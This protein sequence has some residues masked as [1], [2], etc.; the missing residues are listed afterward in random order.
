MNTGDDDYDEFF[1]SLSGD[2]AAMPS[3]PAPQEPAVAGGAGGSE[4]G[5]E[6]VTPTMPTKVPR[7]PREKLVIDAEKLTLDD[8]AKFSSATAIKLSGDSTRAFGEFRSNVSSTYTPREMQEFVYDLATLV[9]SASPAAAAV[10]QRILS[11]GDA[12]HADVASANYYAEVKKR[13]FSDEAELSSRGIKSLEVGG[14]FVTK[15]DDALFYYS[16]ETTKL[17]TVRFGAAGRVTKTVKDLQLYMNPDGSGAKFAFLPPAAKNNAVP[18]SML[19]MMKKARAPSYFIAF[20]VYAPD[21]LQRLCVFE[22]IGGKYVSVGVFGTYE[23]RLKMINPSVGDTSM[24]SKTDTVPDVGHSKAFN[25]CFVHYDDASGRIDADMPGVYPK[26]KIAVPENRAF[27]ARDIVAQYIQES[28]PFKHVAIQY[29]S[30]LESPAQIGIDDLADAVKEIPGAKIVAITEFGSITVA[31][32]WRSGEDLLLVFVERR[33]TYGQNLAPA[34]VYTAR[35]V[36]S[37]NQTTRL[38][39]TVRH[40]IIATLNHVHYYDI[41]EL[42]AQSRVAPSPKAVAPPVS[43]EPAPEPAPVPASPPAAIAQA[44]QPPAARISDAT[45]VALVMTQL[46]TLH[47]GK[48]MFRNMTRRYMAETIVYLARLLRT[49]KSLMNEDD[50]DYRDYLDYYDKPLWQMAT[51]GL[52]F[53]DKHPLYKENKIPPIRLISTQDQVAVRLDSDK[54]GGIVAMSLTDSTKMYHLYVDQMSRKKSAFVQVEYGGAPFVVQETVPQAEREFVLNELLTAR[55]EARAQ[56]LRDPAPF[57]FIQNDEVRSD[58]FVAYEHSPGNEAF[59]IVGQRRGTDAD[60]DDARMPFAALA[61]FSRSAPPAVKLG[62]DIKLAFGS[63]DTDERVVVYYDGNVVQARTIA[64]GLNRT[65]RDPKPDKTSQNA[66]FAVSSANSTLVVA[67]REHPFVVEL[68]SLGGGKRRYIS[69][70]GRDEAD[71]LLAV[72]YL[73]RLVFAVFLTSGGRY[74]LGIAFV[75]DL[76]DETAF[77]TKS[78]AKDAQFGPRY[79]SLPASTTTPDRKNPQ[80]ALL[81]VNPRRLLVSYDDGP[82]YEY[83]FLL[84]HVEK[85]PP[86]LEPV[87][88]PVAPPPIAPPPAEPSVEAAP[89]PA[90]AAPAASSP[91][92][93]PAPAPKPLQLVPPVASTER[94]TNEAAGDAPSLRFRVEADGSMSVTYSP[95]FGSEVLMTRECDAILV[96]NVGNYAEFVDDL[97]FNM[98]RWE[99]EETLNDLCVLLANRRLEYV[100]EIEDEETTDAEGDESGDEDDDD[101][102][103]DEGEELAAEFVEESDFLYTLDEFNDM[104]PNVQEAAKELRSFMNDLSFQEITA[105]GA[106]PDTRAML[107]EARE[108]YFVGNTTTADY[109]N[110]IR[111][112]F[113]DNAGVEA[114][115]RD[116]TRTKDAYVAWLAYRESKDATEERARRKV[117]DA[118]ALRIRALGTSE[119]RQEYEQRLNSVFKSLRTEINRVLIES[120]QAAGET[121]ASSRVLFMPMKDALRVAQKNEDDVRL[122]R[123]RLLESLRR[124]RLDYFQADLLNVR[125]K[126]RALVR[127]INDA[128]VSMELSEATQYEEIASAFLTVI[129]SELGTKAK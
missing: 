87:A 60:D 58:I 11:N 20:R 121:V 119:Q 89:E 29:K 106:E 55:A 74:T 48:K 50:F 85:V 76:L 104:S 32:V 18:E 93:R 98:R 47:P 66:S 94:R 35:G 49:M 114:Y 67:K 24:R 110:R 75:P 8:V 46:R 115:L 22:K 111:T 113:A 97:H 124:T 56:P 65:L 53:A 123:P 129:A 21:P 30:N 19:E 92:K 14:S 61:R 52:L 100:D 91:T 59:V 71:L 79:F 38:Y 39:F 10:R 68:S 1:E 16:E 2:D 15:Y 43:V 90:P 37:S 57:V 109:E 13:I 7:K 127:E 80:R 108:A 23:K 40:L 73:D 78:D 118:A 105:F 3:A 9:K 99:Y 26:L 5:A 82:V 51:Y 27:Y 122:Q 84:A 120:K 34:K 28:P 103:D 95:D 88:V 101:D 125:E 107:I 12:T 102:D 69:F 70:A 41:P 86:K 112:T 31:A 96:S 45:S 33:E 25:L 4:E 17:T 36:R 83:D 62:V 44:P 63:H 54:A 6:R 81:H 77:R 116:V 72:D 64:P 126:L 42:L 117:Y 128:G